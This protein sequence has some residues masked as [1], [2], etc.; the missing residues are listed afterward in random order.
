MV[1]EESKDS[2]TQNEDNLDAE[3]QEIKVIVNKRNKIESDGEEEIE[4]K[5]E[6]GRSSDEACSIGEP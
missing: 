6:I 1:K 3:S 2:R 4:E 5:C